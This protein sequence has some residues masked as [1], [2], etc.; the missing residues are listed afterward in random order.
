MKILVTGG[1]GFIGSNIVDAYVEAGHAVVVVDDLSSGKKSNLNP[2]AKFYQLDITSPELAKVFAAEMPDIVNHHAAQID[3][4]KSIADPA[5]DIKI[6]II[7]VVNVLNCCRAIGGAKGKLP[8]IIFSSTGGALYGE[9]KDCAR[10]DDPLFPVSA[11]A[12]DKRAAEMYLFAYAE[13][14]GIKYTI[15]RYGNVYGPRQDP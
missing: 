14:Y 1:A 9:V 12:I 15:L 10:E 11:Y 8:K 7:G 5:L 13:N 3:V 6:N 2:K 4:R